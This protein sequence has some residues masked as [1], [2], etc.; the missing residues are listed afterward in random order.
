MV[1][2]PN[3]KI[4]IGLNVLEKREDGYHNIESIFYPVDWCD[5]IEATPTEGNGKINLTIFGTPVPGNTDSNLCVKAYHLLNE[6]FNLPSLNAWL[7][8]SIP[9][10]AGMGGGS[11]NAAFFLKMLNHLFELNLSIEELKNYAAQIGSDCTFFI[12]NKPAIVTG[13]GNIITP[14]PL[15][16]SSYYITIVYPQIHID[17]KNAYCLITPKK[18]TNSLQEIALNMPVESWKDKVVND[19]EEPIFKA[20]P[21]LA[22]IKNILYTNG[23]LYASMT[24]SGS[25]LYGIFDKKPVLNTMLPSCK[26]WTSQPKNAQ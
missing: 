18:R 23:A 2:F 14:I 5:A 1:Y 11:A 9:M 8:K 22:E 12:E 3:A 7:L 15:D 25:A 13:T 20:Y 10:G 26:I 19:F 17:T 6:K 16:L 4:N 21:Q 24:G